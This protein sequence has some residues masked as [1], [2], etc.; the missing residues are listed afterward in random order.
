M[1]LPLFGHCANL[2]GAIQSKRLGHVRRTIWQ[3][4]FLTPLLE[5]A[6]LSVSSPS[7]GLARPANRWAYCGKP[8]DR[9]QDTWV[10]VEKE[11]VVP[12]PGGAVVSRPS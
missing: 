5:F 2:E 7:K 4:Y 6:P 3:E 12:L 9:R 1:A 11:G 8:V 10:G